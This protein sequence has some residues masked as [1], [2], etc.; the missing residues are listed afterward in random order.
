LIDAKLIN[1]ERDLPVIETWFKGKKVR[2]ERIYRATEDGF[3]GNAYHAKC[4]NN[5]PLMTIIQS[6]HYRIFG[7]FVNVEFD[8]SNKWYNDP[9][10]FIFSITD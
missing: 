10:A 1:A 5:S 3:N 8:S 4:N 9:D 2:L 6:E 7:G